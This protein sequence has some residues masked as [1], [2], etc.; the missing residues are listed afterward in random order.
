MIPSKVDG[1]NPRHARHLAELMD[2]YPELIMPT[3]IGYRSSIADGLATQCPVWA[4]KRTS[5]RPAAREVRAMAE[6]IQNKM[7]IA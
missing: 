6:Y 4:I 2:A 5:A 7:E 3:P 1:R